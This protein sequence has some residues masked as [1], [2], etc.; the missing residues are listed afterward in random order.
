MAGGKILLVD[1]EIEIRQFLQ[2]Y[3]EDRDYNVEVA[4]D[5]VAAFEKFQKNN[6]DLVVCDML[7]PKMLGTEFLRKVKELKPDQRV[8][9]MTAVKEDSMVQKARTLGCRH[10]LTKP[11]RL[12]DLEAKVLECLSPSS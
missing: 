8:I 7:M 9:M 12:A 3:F 11:L 6:F 4:S 1:D 2:V 5:G 10:Y